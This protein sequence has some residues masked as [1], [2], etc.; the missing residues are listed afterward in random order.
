M[1]ETIYL[2]FFVFLNFWFWEKIM[3]ADFFSGHWRTK[4]NKNIKKILK[5]HHTIKLLKKGTILR[6]APQI[7]LFLT[8]P[9]LSIF[10]SPPAAIIWSLITAKFK[11]PLKV[12]HIVL[13]VVTGER[14]FFHKNERN[15][16]ECSMSSK[17][18]KEPSS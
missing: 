16:Q 17:K 12:V 4:K 15:N 6:Q 7:T 18:K 14:S 1:I 5:K 10:L 9:V 13:G 11:I 8:H 2:H 3:F